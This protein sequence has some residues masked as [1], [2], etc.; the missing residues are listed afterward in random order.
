MLW[1]ST[2]RSLIWLPPITHKCKT[3][4]EHHGTRLEVLPSHEVH[5]CFCTD[6]NSTRYSFRPYANSHQP[7]LSIF[8]QKLLLWPQ[9]T[10]KTAMA[11][12]VCFDRLRELQLSSWWNPMLTIGRVP[13]EST[14]H[15]SPKLLLWEWSSRQLQQWPRWYSDSS[16]SYICVFWHIQQYPGDSTNKFVKSSIW[17]G[18][19]PEC[20][21]VTHPTSCL[22]STMC[23]R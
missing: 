11:N 1:T 9:H 7:L 16:P 12:R 20:R 18:R 8:H 14:R 13:S 17:N 19:A 3:T 15:R 23:R 4:W 5:K 10:D 22:L 21:Y 6:Q 2:L